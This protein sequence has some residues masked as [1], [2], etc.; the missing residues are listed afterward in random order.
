MRFCCRTKET[1][2]LHFATR[3]ADERVG[4]VTVAAV[5]LIVSGDARRSM[6]SSLFG[7]LDWN[8]EE[9]VEAAE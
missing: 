2:R 5:S 7:D 8:W 9:R 3:S 4:Q 6:V 1:G